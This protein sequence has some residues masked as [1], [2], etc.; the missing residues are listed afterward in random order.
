[1]LSLPIPLRAAALRQPTSSLL[2]QFSTTPSPPY[3]QRPVPYSSIPLPSTTAIQPE[4]PPYPLGP[5]QTYHQS[6]TGLYGSA[7]I[8]FGNNVSKKNEIKT[9][10]K[11][12]PNVQHKNLWSKSLG[13]YIRTRLTTRVLRTIDK[14]GGIDEY[15]LGIKPQRIAD[16]GP[17]GWRLRWRVMQTPAVKE[18]FQEEQK[19]LGIEKSDKG[20]F[21][22]LTLPDGTVVTDREFR[23][24]IRQMDRLLAEK[25]AKA[26]VVLAEEAEVKET[27]FMKEDQ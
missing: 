14:V 27:R 21:V 1:M 18:R 9:R 25:R 15:L 12:R 8:R 4:I 2:R 11:W 23:K 3:R 19:A 6:N 13:T 17:W 16:L 26:Q 7:T 20:K 24:Y 5:R 22:Q 10:R